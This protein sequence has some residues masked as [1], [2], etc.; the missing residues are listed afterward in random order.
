M[1]S[2]IRSDPAGNPLKSLLEPCS[3]GFAREHTAIWI[4]RRKEKNITERGIGVLLIRAKR[5][6]LRHKYLR[7][8]GRYHRPP[9]AW[10]RGVSHVCLVKDSDFSSTMS[11][12]TFWGLAV[13][14]DELRPSSAVF[15]LKQSRQAALLISCAVPSRAGEALHYC[16]VF[17]ASVQHRFDVSFA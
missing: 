12:H 3:I 14:S 6:C 16:S 8:R 15:P 17:H 4:E 1:G 9:V 5:C 2:G 13:H 7:S 10:Q 11:M